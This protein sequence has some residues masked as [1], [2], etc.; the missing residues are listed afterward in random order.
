MIGYYAHGHGSGHCNTA[1]LFSKVFG[2]AMTIFTDR[3]YSFDTAEQVVML[4]NENP[5]GTEFTRENFPEPRGL[6]YAPIN[7][8][9]IT[10][11]N[12]MMLNT[13][14]EKNISLLIIDVSVEVAMLSRVSSVPYAYVRLQGD[15]N[16]FPHLNAY[17]GASFLLA[18]FPKEMES[19]NTPSWVARKTVYL[20]FISKYMFDDKVSHRPEEFG[21]GLRPILLY[22][23][24][25]GGSSVP[26][27]GT[28][29]E[30]HDTFVIGPGRV[31][32]KSLGLVHIGVV[33]NTKPFIEHADVIVA[34]CG[35]N[36]TS[37]ILSLGKTFVAISENRHYDEQRRMAEHLEQNGWA[38]DL[39]RHHDVTQAVAAMNKIEQRRV[40][41]ISVNQ[42][43]AFKAKLECVNY[44]ADR[45]VRSS[46]SPS[47]SKL[48]L[49]RH[50]NGTVKV[51]PFN[52]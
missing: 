38:V 32:G 43:K 34:A 41:N 26:N 16:D 7:M 29:Y 6:H 9:K 11:R 13:I 4:D 50:R 42:L 40:P 15:R 12:L 22:L 49:R 17:E 46:R 1:N 23:T 48:S 19:L 45:F 25:F 33:G 10:K 30:T 27:F 36:T 37:E 18:Y 21:N 14:L 24:G 35:A 8:S 51:E 2:K 44:R 28:I 3:N 52:L 47:T 20:G 5:D 39:Q 31:V